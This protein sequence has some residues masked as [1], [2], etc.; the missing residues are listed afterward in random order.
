[1]IHE[2]E[3]TPEEREALHAAAARVREVT[4]TINT[5]TTV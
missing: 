1:V 2:W 5:P 3:I 4:D